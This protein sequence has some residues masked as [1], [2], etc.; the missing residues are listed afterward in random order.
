MRGS[1]SRG[2]TRPHPCVLSDSRTGTGDGY[3]QHAMS[4]K[5]ADRPTPPPTTR[6]PPKMT[7]DA[8]RAEVATRAASGAPCEVWEHVGGDNPK[9]R[10]LGTGRLMVRPA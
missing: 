1:P 4:P 3:R 7:K 9:G 8:A 10:I 2:D 6:R 5:S